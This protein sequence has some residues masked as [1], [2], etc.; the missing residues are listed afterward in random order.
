MFPIKTETINRFWHYEFQEFV[1]E[2]CDWPEYR[3][4]DEY[5]H[6]YNGSYFDFTVDGDTELDSIDD[7]KIL[8]AWLNHGQTVGIEVCDPDDGWSYE[9]SVGVKHILHRLFK[10]GKIPAGDYMMEYWW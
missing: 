1:R 9:V 5:E 6:A 10:E 4:G 3:V 8:D 2:E 7:D